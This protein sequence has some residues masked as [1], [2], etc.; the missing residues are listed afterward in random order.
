MPMRLCVPVAL[1]VGRGRESGDLKEV[2][3]PRLVPSQVVAII[4]QLF[5]SAGPVHEAVRYSSSQ[6]HSLQGVL[7]LVEQIPNELL[8]MTPEAYSDCILSLATIRRQIEYWCSR[9]DVGYVQPVKNQSPVALIRAALVQCPDE[10]PSPLTADLGFIPETDLR[11]SIRRDVSA[12]NQALHGGEWKAA[13]VL[14]GSTIEALLLWGVQQPAYAARLA[15]AGDAAVASGALS[16]KPL[17]NPEQWLLHEF[18]EV[19]AQLGLI[20]TDT[21][22]AARLA[23]DFRNLIHPGRAARLGQVCDRATALSAVAAL[24]HVVRDLTR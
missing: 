20:T 2:A 16:T 8:T 22:T 9:G 15:T 12:A 13:T 3:M 21:R 6:M 14:A 17:S 1:L 10:A 11:D 4:D 23:K 24:E 19:S 7:D 5:P 18:I